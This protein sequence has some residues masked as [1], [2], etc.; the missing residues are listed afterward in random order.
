MTT[1]EAEFVQ[2][3]AR[4]LE[5]GFAK[6]TND[7]IK[8][9]Y[10]LRHFIGAKIDGVSIEDI[11]LRTYRGQGDDRKLYWQM[12]V[13]IPDVKNRFR[14]GLR[15][16]V[17]LHDTSGEVTMEDH[18]LAVSNALIELQ[19]LRV[20]R[21]NGEI[22]RDSFDSHSLRTIFAGSAIALPPI[23]I[24]SI[25]HEETST[26]DHCGSYLCVVCFSDLCERCYSP[27][28]PTCR[29]YLLREEDEMDEDE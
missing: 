12:Q 8:D 14:D 4:E 9:I 23:N 5:A 19:K 25:C 22:H 27:K 16:C 20:D 21:L 10:M 24:C 11:Y 2:Y 29:G 13:A 1:T 18:I 7:E 6:S 3:Y 17:L 26:K 15:C 28:C